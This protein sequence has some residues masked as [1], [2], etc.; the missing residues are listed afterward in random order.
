MLSQVLVVLAALN[1]G[2]LSAVSKDIVD[3]VQ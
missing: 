3:G 1:N 2:F